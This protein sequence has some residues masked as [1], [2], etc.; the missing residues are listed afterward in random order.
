M[1]LEHTLLVHGIELPSWQNLSSIP[2]G[3]MQVANQ[4]PTTEMATASLGTF[5][6]WQSIQVSLPQTSTPLAGGSGAYST[7]PP[8]HTDAHIP[9]P[10][11][12]STVDPPTQLPTGLSVPQPF[13]AAE[14]SPLDTTAVGV[15]FV[16]VLEHI[17]MPHHPSLRPAAGSNHAF[18]ASTHILSYTD[19]ELTTQTKWDVP[20]EDMERLLS[21][22]LQIDLDGEITPVQAWARLRA[23]PRFGELD[24]GGLRELKGVLGREVSCLG[25]GAVI[26][27]EVF[28]TKVDAF[29]NNL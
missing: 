22:S 11:Q 4:D 23:H 5:D 25:F 19:A 7:A 26:D 1:L 29:L 8:V 12:S 3:D 6:D 9:Y 27:E 18:T 20:R 28:H 17:C 24:G 21:L 16:L 14:R 13:P 15:D 2:Q 10:H